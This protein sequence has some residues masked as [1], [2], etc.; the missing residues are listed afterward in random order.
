M[1]AVKSSHKIKYSGDLSIGVV[2]RYNHVGGTNADNSGMMLETTTRHNQWVGATSQMAK[3]TF[4]NR[5]A[6]LNAKALIALTISTVCVPVHRIQYSSLRYRFRRTTTCT[7][8]P[9]LT[10][11]SFILPVVVDYRCRY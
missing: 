8:V 6:E 1:K 3:N 9:V 5:H 4:S 11:G 7:A 2:R 10:V